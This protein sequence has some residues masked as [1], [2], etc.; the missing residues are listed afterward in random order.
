MCSSAL[1]SNSTVSR[2]STQL[3][4]VTTFSSGS[5]AGSSPDG[6]AGP[7]AAG[8]SPGGTSPAGGGS[9]C[10][11]SCDAAPAPGSDAG[12]SEPKSAAGTKP[13]TRASGTNSEGWSG[14]NGKGW[15]AGSGGSDM[16]HSGSIGSTEETAGPLSVA[17][18]VPS[19]RSQPG[20]PAGGGAAA[21]RSGAKPDGSVGGREKGWPTG[22]RGGGGVRSSGRS[23]GR[24]ASPNAAGRYSVTGP[25]DGSS[26]AAEPANESR[27][28]SGRRSPSSPR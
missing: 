27:V 4:S 23:D 7:S 5:G 20:A 22:S 24:V 10:A 6:P 13:P 26:T 11:P 8:A 18:C 19:S 2:P 1:I 16:P 28:P 9:G 25:R 12:H 17:A 15:R 3:D 14:G 21:R